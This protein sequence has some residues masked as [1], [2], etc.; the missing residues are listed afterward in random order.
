MLWA[1]KVGIIL[2]VLNKTVMKIRHAE[3]IARLLN[4]FE[5]LTAYGIIVICE[6]SIALC[7]ECFLPHVVPTT[8][9]I[10]IDITRISAKFPKS[11]S[12]A[13][14]AIGCGTDVIIV[15]NKNPLV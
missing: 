11:L 13:L 7:Y 1:N 15:R 9:C 10:K 2:Y 3:K 5:R 4:L 14:V 6:L 12:I 8:V